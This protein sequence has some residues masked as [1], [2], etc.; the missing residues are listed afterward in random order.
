MAIVAS[1][2]ITLVDLNDTKQLAMYIGASQSKT[3]VYDGVK[4]Y[5]PDYSVSNQTLTPQL[6]VAGSNEDVAESATSCRWYY[7]TN[8]A[9]APIEITVDTDDYSLVQVG[10]SNLKALTIKTNLLS[11]N[12]SMTYICELVYLDSDSGISSTI[13]MEIEIVKITNGLDGI[14]GRDAVIGLLTNEISNVIAETN[15]NVVSYDGANTQLTIYK[16]IVDDTDNWS[17]SQKRHNVTVAEDASSRTAT[18][19]A[20]SDDVGS[21][22]FTATRSGYPTIVKIFKVIKVKSGVDGEDAISYTLN[23]ST[24]VLSLNK[25][26]DAFNPIDVS[27]SATFQVGRAEPFDYPTMFT[28]EETLD[29]STYTV[30]YTS[31]AN[32][33]SFVYTPSSYDIKSL[34]VK[35]YLEDDITTLLDQQTI[36]VVYDGSD[37]IY[38][39]VWTP[40]GNAI[41][42]GEGII[43]AQVD[44]YYGTKPIAASNYKWYI[45]DETATITSGGDNDG[46]DGWRLLDDSYNLGTSGYGT[47]KLT[48]PPTAI[49][50]TEAFKSVVAYNGNNYYG[51]TTVVDLSDPYQIR[52]D[53]M[54][55][56]KN[57]E[58]LITV[59]ATILKSGEEI[60]PDGSGKYTYNWYIYDASNNKTSFVK[61]GK[62]ITINA[63]DING[64][65]NLVCEVY[66]V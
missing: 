34:R 46:G 28:V 30:T 11:Q 5:T 55:K 37:A 36:P 24:P 40:D 29:G 57:G 64:R 52:L 1:G 41:K 33:Y 17:I 63:T 27:V 7:Q 59:R 16:G 38:A 60:D 20:M 58:G 56:F 3:V 35:M 39:N 18:I 19:T 42:N 50:G 22:T 13:K 12:T 44:L 49:V 15:G 32:E 48:I 43:T 47:E 54:D 26:R 10:T 23:V 53:G 51:V 2:Q 9:N 61:S 21:V 31:A 45:Q 4:N 66:A 25:T 8:G 14:S 6:Y 62:T 65:G